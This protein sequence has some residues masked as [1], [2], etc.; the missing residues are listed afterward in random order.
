M[1]APHSFYAQPG[2]L[3]T[4][5]DSPAIRALLDGLP[6]AIPD[7]VK[8]VQ[9]NLLHIFWAKHYGVELSDAR[10][11]EVNLRTTAAR[12]QRIYD[13]D[14]EPLVVPRAAHERSIGNCR[15]FTLM[16]CTLLRHRGIPARARCGFGTY[17]VPLRYEDHWI[18]EYWS[19]DQGRW[20]GVDAQLDTLQGVKLKIDFNPLDVPRTRFI[21]GGLAWQM[22]R[23][24]G[25]SPDRFGIFDMHGLWFVRGDMLRDLAALNKVELLPWDSWGLMLGSDESISVE[26]RAFL[27]H[28]A[29]LTL[30][31][32]ESFGEVRALYKSE[33]RV[34]VPAV[35]SSFD[36]GPTPTP[37]TL[38]AIP[39]IVPPAPET[40]AELIALIHARR[41]ALEA[42]IAPLDEA[43]LTRPDLDGG[44]SIKDLLAHIAGW[45]RQ[46]L[47]WYRDG[48]HGATFDL[49]A[50]GMTWQDVERFNQQMHQDY[51]DRSLAE[52]RT[53]FAEARADLLAAIAGMSEDEIF[54]VGHYA[55]TRQH[56]L[57]VY[58]RANSDE[59]DAEHTVQIAAR[60][61]Q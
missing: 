13:A 9:N 49:P 39:G 61:A 40:K 28:V 45:E 51:R 4:L 30:A 34:R 23:Q 2:P 44:W 21:P 37:I 36:S 18:C 10:K 14:P 11:T 38:D 47:R 26:D 32:D 6:T 12:L 31:G 56:P 43:A 42:V 24:Q 5:P 41:Q 8:V 25:V 19:A 54:T 29:A 7:L 1:S 60:L 53:L 35:F 52:V 17:F 22:C 55:W 33:A 50:P 58:L 48:Q 20:I 46:C 59:H 16:L 3:S 57:L 15:D 27:D